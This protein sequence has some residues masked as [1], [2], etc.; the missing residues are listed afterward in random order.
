MFWSNLLHPLS[1][2]RM[3]KVNIGRKQNFHLKT[4]LYIYQG[5]RCHILEETNFPYYIYLIPFITDPRNNSF[6]RRHFLTNIQTDSWV[7]SNYTF[8]LTLYSHVVTPRVS[9]INT[10]KSS[11]C[12]HSRFRCVVRTSEQRATMSLREH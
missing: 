10:Q 9:R 8:L 1:W 6:W 2:K 3:A 11:F 4:S 7:T 12:F 5:R